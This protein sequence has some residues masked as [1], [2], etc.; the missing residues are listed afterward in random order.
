MGRMKDLSR[1]IV[2]GGNKKMKVRAKKKKEKKQKTNIKPLQG[3]GTL[4]R[5]S[6]LGKPAYTMTRATA[7][8]KFSFLIWNVD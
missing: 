7:F 1:E 3:S 8:P 6:I 2:Q 4:M 5:T